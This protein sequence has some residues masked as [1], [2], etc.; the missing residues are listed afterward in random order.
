MIDNARLFPKLSDHQIQCAK[1][2]GQEVQLSDG[3]VIFRE[4]QGAA[5]F[6]V[7]LDGKIK[8]TRNGEGNQETVL[9]VHGPGDFTGTTDLLTGEAATATGLAL[10][11]TRVV[12]VKAEQFR[13][14]L[15]VCPEM[16]ALLLPALTERRTAEYAI[17]VQQEKLAALGKLSAGL[18][19]ELNNPASAARRSAQGLTRLLSDIEGISCHMLQSVMSK[20]N[21]DGAALSSVCALA[22]HNGKELD[23][24]TRSDREQELGEWLSSQAVPDA[25]EA[26]ASL[27]AA[28]LMREQ[29]EPLANRVAPP[30]LP[31]VLSWLAKDVEI[32][33]LCQE[34]EQ[35]TTR[36]S[37]L[38]GA[39]KSYTYMDRAAAKSPVNLHEG[40]DTTLTILKHKLKKKDVSVR[41]EY[42]QLPPV[43]AFGGELNQVWT[44]LIDN[45]IDAV[46]K[47]GHVAIR[48][49]REGD[50]AC[51][52]ITDDGPGIP[53][54]VGPKIFEPF[55]TTKG[56]GE[57]TGLGLDTTYRIIR[58]HHGDIRFDSHPGQTRFTVYLP[59]N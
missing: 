3:E 55:F 13:D 52:E 59:L 32:R 41:R 42:G 49:V 5:D 17:A 26:A 25:W 39:M 30:Q 28:G 57:G 2:V 45:A 40:I 6:F 56:V 21:G 15:M 4:N 11:P 36:I 9:V 29:I 48:T 51:V 46:P 22:R 54:E 18:A 47:G 34:L 19:H 58:N 44:N 27:V 1:E 43:P 33:L 10:G 31:R 35:S 50:Q 53:P 14:L 38:V 8:V 37:E 12:R 23:P 7:I 16:R 24:I 20:T